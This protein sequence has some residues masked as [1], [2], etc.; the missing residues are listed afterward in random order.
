MTAGRDAHPAAGEGDRDRPAVQAIPFAAARRRVRDGAR[1]C[2]LVAIP[3]QAGGG[4]GL[5]LFAITSDDG[6]LAFEEHRPVDGAYATLTSDVPAADWYE[7]RIHDLFGI[8]PVGR[9]RP[10]PL[11]FPVPPGA[12]PPLAAGGDPSAALAPDPSP[13]P[14]HVHGEGVFTIP[15]GP[16]RS[17]VFE[18]VEYLVE[19]S[20][21]D[22]PHLRTRIFYKHRGVDACFVG[23]DV[24]DGALLAEREEGPASVAHAL[25]FSQAVER[26]AEAAVPVAAQLVRVVHAELERVANHLDTMVRHT[27]AAG[28]A[29]AYAVLSHHKERV[30]R[31]RARLCGSRFG[32]GVVVPGGVRRPPGLSPHGVL[33]EV[34]E[35]QRRIDQD[36]Q[37]LMDTP[38]FVDRLRGT[39]V[40]SSDDARRFAVVGPIGRASGEEEDVRMSRPYGAYERL[41]HRVARRVEGGDALARQR[42]RMDELDGSFHLVRQAVDMLAELGETGGWRAAIPPVS[43]RAVGWTE[44]A[45]GELLSVVEARDGRLAHVTQR[46]AS[47]HNLAAYGSAFPKDIFTDVAFIEASFGLSIAGAAG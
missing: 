32:R 10:E 8:E 21:E 33:S 15:Y 17:G 29:V 18:S 12:R 35:L 19:T 39:G 6:E 25:A 37:R 45:Q 41:G 16:V 34:G 1:F 43:G 28:Q 9:Q 13:T 44:A 38:S 5:G 46:S 4:G 2:G 14:A 31:L 24:D 22:I 23:L 26:M 42:V 3:D 36:V 11:V 27:E 47:F 20:G 40:L 7:R 30:Q